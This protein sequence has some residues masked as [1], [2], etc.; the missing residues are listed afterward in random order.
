[1]R[2]SR[3][4]VEAD[5]SA[6]ARFEPACAGRR[7]AV[8]IGRGTVV[9]LLIACFGAAGCSRQA[10]RQWKY[11]SLDLAMQTALPEDLSRSNP[12]ERREAVAR[13]AESGDYA[14]Q[15]VFP[16]LDAVAR[17]DPVSQ[18]RCIAIRGL[19]R[20]RDDRPVGTLLAILQASKPGDKALPADDDV[21][22]EVLH[23]LLELDQR[24]ALDESQR[25]M[26][27]DLAIRLAEFDPSRNVRVTATEL[28]G[29]FKDR[30]V[31][32]PLIRLVRD[33]DFA[34]AERAEL[35]LIAL[36]G[37][38][39]DFDAD[40]WEKWLANTPDPF[41]RAGQVPQTTRPAPPSW[42]E[43]QQRAIRRALKL[44]GWD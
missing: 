2:T 11:R 39:H 26:V 3:I 41:A 10:K 40:A 18:I 1:M 4:T 19:S 23:A 29:C 24:N 38:T 5:S 22:W 7:R 44:G 42:L 33:K 15:E 16:V 17:T 9:V 25:A 14:R 8:M 36:T 32:S 43:K 37:T 30:A 6:A 34:I 12:D 21:R 28:L 13:L 27:R 20:Y 31:L 35:S